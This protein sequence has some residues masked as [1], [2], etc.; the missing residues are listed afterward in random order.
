MI[1]LTRILPCYHKHV[2]RKMANDKK[3]K[4]EQDTNNPK[5]LMLFFEDSCYRKISHFG[6]KSLCDDIL[7]FSVHIRIYD[8]HVK[9]GIR[10]GQD[11]KT[12]IKEFISSIVIAMRQSKET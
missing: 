4:V 6:I 12:Q 1:N 5:N 9:E 11:I 7:N 2:I 8:P 10:Q 3:T